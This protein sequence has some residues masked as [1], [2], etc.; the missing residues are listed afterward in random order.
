MPRRQKEQKRDWI[1]WLRIAGTV[2]GGLVSFLFF[3]IFAIAIFGSGPSLGAP[4]AD[5]A[6]IP[7]NGIIQ[8]DTD[9]FGADGTASPEQ[10]IAWLKDANESDSIKGIILEIDSPGGSPVASD[11]IASAVYKF[12]RSKP[13]VAVIRETG[14]SG[15]YWVA[16]SA[17]RIF[18]NRMSVTGS[19]GV[20]ASYLEFGGFLSRYNVTYQRLVSGKYKDVGSPFR[21][22]KADEQD[23][24][25][26]LLDKLHEEFMGAVAENRRLP[27]DVVRN[28]ST[29]FVFLGE[30]AQ[31]L[32]LVDEIGGRDEA[33]AYLAERLNITDPDVGEFEPAR[34]FLDLFSVSFE[35]PFYALGRGIA[36]AL[37]ARSVPTVRT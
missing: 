4:S 13:I 14:A 29:G 18:A 37:E 8:S 3:L 9:G 1:E 5:I 34:G 12:R 24:F 33:V 16:T 30:E 26:D 35:R 31:R 21:P 10:I 2:F 11:E 7:F 25:Q 23:L 32:G 6:I 19:I 28:L 15:A 27:L 20:T 17:D 22:L 36:S